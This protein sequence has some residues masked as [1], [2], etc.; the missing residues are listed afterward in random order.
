MPSRGN[1]YGNYER[2]EKN[3]IT[4]EMD[5]GHED[6][7]HDTF[8]KNYNDMLR[9]LGTEEGDRLREKEG[10]ATEKII[11]E[12]NLHDSNL[13]DSFMDARNGIVN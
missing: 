10:E 8:M 5:Q 7:G 13:M 1:E 3:T 4:E 2:F 12:P 11:T 9:Q 6:N